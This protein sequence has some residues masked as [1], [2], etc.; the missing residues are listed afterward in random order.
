MIVFSKLI[1]LAGVTVSVIG[2]Q[3]FAFAH[4]HAANHSHVD[5]PEALRPVHETLGVKLAFDSPFCDSNGNKNI[6]DDELRMD[7]LCPNKPSF[8]IFTMKPIAA[9]GLRQGQLLLT[10]D[11]GP[12]PKITPQI[13]DLLDAY[14]IKATFFL[15]GSLIPSNEP[16]IREMVRRGHTVSN[17]TYTHDVPRI[18]P[19]TIVGEVTRAHHA[20]TKALGQPPK[21]RLL[22]RAPGLGWSAPK[23]VNLNNDALTRNYIGPIHANLGTDAPRA[24]WACWSQGVSAQACAGY[25]FQ[26]IVNAGRGIVLT[27]DIYFKAGRGNTFE[28]L[29]I[30]LNRLHVEAGGIKNRNG[31]G[32]WEFMN[33]QNLSALDQYETN[34]APIPAPQPARRTQD[35]YLVIDSFARADVYIRTELL[36]REGAV[37]PNSLIS[38]GARNLKTS[39]LIAVADLE[40]EIVVGAVKFKKVRIEETKPGLE[41]LRGQVVYVWTAAF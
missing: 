21:G 36:A 40:R 3:S 8:F 1:A 30:L 16:L 38:L 6:E 31:S 26:D 2:L 7:N 22:F 12:N 25:Y 28:M 10:I 19:A 18:T 9:L 29:K 35:G 20:L 17:H 32:L 27:H 23:A 34:P 13:L 15:V 33:V 41:A 11:D 37:T 4:D 14:G 5:V 39:D 24:D